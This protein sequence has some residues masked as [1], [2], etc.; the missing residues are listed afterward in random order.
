VHTTRNAT[1]AAHLS[2]LDALVLVLFT[3]DRTVVPKESSWFGSYAVP[4]D[5]GYKDDDYEDG[6]GE[7]ESNTIVPMY[8]QPLY[9]EDWIGLRTLDESGRVVLASCE[10]VHMELSAECWQP[11]VQQYVGAPS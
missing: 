11:L 3:K 7:G 10:G 5:G 9:I 8:E 1:Y 6:V 4:E 2:Q